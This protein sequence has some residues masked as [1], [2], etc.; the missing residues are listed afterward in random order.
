MILCLL[1]IHNRNFIRFQIDSLRWHTSTYETY[2]YCYQIAKL[3]IVNS[4]L[5]WIISIACNGKAPQGLSMHQRLRF[6]GM[7]LYILLFKCFFWFS[8]E[9]TN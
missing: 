6:P 9:G 1:S 4:Y 7:K 2:V 3:Y 8:N 5:L